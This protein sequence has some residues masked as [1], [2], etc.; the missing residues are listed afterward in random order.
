MSGLK[1]GPQPGCLLMPYVDSLGSAATSLCTSP[2]PAS[3]QSKEVGEAR[4]A[5]EVTEDIVAL[6]REGDLV[7]SVADE[8]GF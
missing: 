3:R 1:L 2:L 8:A 5:T 6:L 7:D 4:T